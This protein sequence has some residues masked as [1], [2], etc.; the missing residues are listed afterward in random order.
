MVD[1]TLAVW[2]NRDRQ[3][4]HCV[5]IVNQPPNPVKSRLIEHL[6]LFPLVAVEA[7]GDGGG[8]DGADAEK[9]ARDQEQNAQGLESVAAN[10]SGDGCE[11]RSQHQE[12]E[13]QGDEDNGQA[14][15]P[16]L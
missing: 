14:S 15:R 1:S 3:L 4:K 12:D 11:S 2:D 10:P 6:A 7:P 13:S 9:H 5:Q 16:F 8:N